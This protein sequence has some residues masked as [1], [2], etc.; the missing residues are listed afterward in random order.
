MPKCEPQI[1][2][3]HCNE[4]MPMYWWARTESGHIEKE[5]KRTHTT[6][7]YVWNM[8]S[9]QHRVQGT[10]RLHHTKTSSDVHCCCCCFS[11][12]NTPKYRFLHA[13]CV[14]VRQTLLFVVIKLQSKL[15]EIIL[16]LGILGGTEGPAYICVSDSLKFSIFEI[17]MLNYGFPHIFCRSA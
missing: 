7:T 10:K 15:F 2:A 5:R 8:Q 1:D 6:V 11:A 14:L 13:L 16:K 3:A 12:N 9:I 4:P 17:E